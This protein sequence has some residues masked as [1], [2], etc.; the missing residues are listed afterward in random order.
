MSEKTVD[1]LK[2]DLEKISSEVSNPRFNSQKIRYVSDNVDK[3]KKVYGSVI[4]F[5]ETVKNNEA[6][7][8]LST[9]DLIF[10]KFAFHTEYILL[11]DITVNGL[12]DYINLVNRESVVDYSK[13]VDKQKVEE[14]L[15]TEL[16]RIGFKKQDLTTLIKWFFD[17][18][19]IFD[20]IDTSPIEDIDDH[21]INQKIKEEEYKSPTPLQKENIF[22]TPN[23]PNEM[24]ISSLFDNDDYRDYGNEDDND[25]DNDSQKTTKI[26]LSTKI[27]KPKDLL[28]FDGKNDNYFINFVLKYIDDNTTQNTDFF[29]FF[30][31]LKTPPESYLIG[32]VNYY[33]Y[34]ENIIDQNIFNFRENIKLLSLKRKSFKIMKKSIQSLNI[35]SSKVEI[36]VIYDNLFAMWRLIMRKI[37]EI[38]MKN[39]TKL[40]KTKIEFTNKLTDKEQLILY[41]NSSYIIEMLMKSISY[42]IQFLDKV[43]L[44]KFNY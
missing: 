40:L 23:D 13:F 12:V 11:N 16:F 41:N 15:R 42:Q 30:T 29:M 2:K 3:F 19:N 33:D 28:I 18:K 14:D 10:K 17:K 26:E 1:E 27:T 32:G 22:S 37:D 9:I 36:H 24:N 21:H 44:Y 4:G 5:E 34:F 38:I 7:Q 39:K 8:K 43:L 31:D 20:D 35:K 25:Y 6:Y